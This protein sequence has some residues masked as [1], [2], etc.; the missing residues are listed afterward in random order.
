MHQQSQFSFFV[1]SVIMR[2]R[3]RFQINHTLIKKS[4]LISSSFMKKIVFKQ[5]NSL[6]QCSY[7]EQP[8]S[9]I[10]LHDKFLFIISLPFVGWIYD[11]WRYYPSSFHV[12]GIS[13]FISCAIMLWPWLQSR[14][15]KI[16]ENNIIE[17]SI[18]IMSTK[19][20]VSAV[21]LESKSKTIVFR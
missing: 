5:V 18:A 1:K 3:V 8:I 7:K 9:R 16:T 12:G 15:K 13:M 20:E 6:L 11:T 21:H 4:Q 14:N 2:S 19:E 10:F 17:K